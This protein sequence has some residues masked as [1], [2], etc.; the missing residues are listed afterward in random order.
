MATHIGIYRDVAVVHMA[1]P[2]RPPASVRNGGG[3]GSDREV[4]AV[5]EPF[6][7]YGLIEIARH[8]VSTCCV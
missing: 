4:E 2:G 3:D 7:V 1:V 8:A 5:R 6:E